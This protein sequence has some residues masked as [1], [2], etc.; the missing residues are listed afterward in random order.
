M[1]LAAVPA[2]SCALAVLSGCQQ[3]AET[4]SQASP[5][6]TYASLAQ[7]PDWSGWW[8]GVDGP[9]GMRLYRDSKDLYLPVASK[10]LDVFFS[11]TNI[12]SHGEHCL[13]FSFVGHNGGFF[14]DVEFL[15][16]P[17]RL[18]IT[19]ESGLLRRIDLD[20][21]P[22]RDNPEE[23]NPGTSV[24]QWDG[25]SLHIQTTGLN[26]SALF[27][28]NAP[29][30]ATLGKNASVSE[31]LWLNARQ[32]LVIEAELTAP[33]MLKA[34]LKFTVR[35]EREPGHIVREHN[36]C[37]TKD[38]QIDPV[39]GLQRFDMTPPADLPPPPPPPRT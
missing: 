25:K 7:L 18:T 21:R 19:N 13:P 20:G 39:T 33:E 17:G 9:G 24:G 29:S 3:Q 32:Q 23:T 31:K 5:G 22:L 4:S 36:T 14:E 15:F 27:P 12:P 37:V 8:R 35:Y 38:R 10:V 6:S 30:M 28:E 1:K 26:S 16:T 11:D 34:P 2:L